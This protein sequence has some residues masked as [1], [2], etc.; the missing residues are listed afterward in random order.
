MA[1]GSALAARARSAAFSMSRLGAS[2]AVKTATTPSLPASGAS[3]R[4]VSPAPVLWDSSKPARMGCLGT[5]GTMNQ[6]YHLRSS[7]TQFTRYCQ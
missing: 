3:E 5:K 6:W 7:P 4:M 2:S 1:S